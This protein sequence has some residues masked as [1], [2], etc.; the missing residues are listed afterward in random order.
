M[1]RSIEDFIKDW[2][3][4]TE[5]TLKV[6]GALTDQTIREKVHPEVRSLE[7]LAWHL[8]QS[9]TEMGTRAGLFAADEL[10]GT[11][12]PAAIPELMDTYKKYCGL[13][14]K[15]LRS[16]WTDSALAD[17]TDMYGEPWEKGKVLRVLI[18]HQ[19]HHRGQ[20]TVIMRLLGLPV[21]G[22]CGPSK[23]EWAQFGMVAPE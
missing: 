5:S 17:T 18:A 8:T 21:P 19:T 16:K 7:R 13:L 2:E 22:V 20:M 23:E 9:I 10:E 3:E 4:E 15:A 6:I 14:I 1:Y 11:S 12:P